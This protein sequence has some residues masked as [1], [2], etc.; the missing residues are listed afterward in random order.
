MSINSKMTAIANAIRS[1]TGETGLMSLDQMA[2]KIGSISEVFA[3]IEVFYDAGASCTC[4]NQDGAAASRVG[5]NGH[6][7]FPIPTEGEW[8]VAVAGGKSRTLTIA[9]K[10]QME[11]VTLLSELV[12]FD[13]T[14]TSGFTLLNSNVTMSAGSASI[15]SG[16]MTVAG[17]FSTNA[18]EYSTLYYKTMPVS[19]KDFSTAK[20]TV[21]TV[22]N[23]YSSAMG[24]QGTRPKLVIQA[25]P[26]AKITAANVAEALITGSG[27]YSCTL[28]SGTYFVG[29]LVNSATRVTA[30][31]IWFE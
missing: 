31:K 21:G 12:L 3:V 13:S 28:P 8:T 4:V 30:S 11:T 14:V 9:T 26:T 20:I 5:G 24:L 7:L 23:T 25:E 18:D 2:E 6:C 22:E 15:D 17:K 19:T 29:V 10:G 1:R 16:I 27:T